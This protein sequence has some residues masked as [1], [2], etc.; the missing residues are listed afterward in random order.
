MENFGHPTLH[1]APP[2][3]VSMEIDT[4]PVLEKPTLATRIPLQEVNPQGQKSRLC[5]LQISKFPIRAE[6]SHM[7]ISEKPTSW[8]AGDT[9]EAS[10]VPEILELI[11]KTFLQ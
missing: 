2:G 4:G 9:W 10:L 6:R 8:G 3:Q 1:A 5:A 11:R 7:P